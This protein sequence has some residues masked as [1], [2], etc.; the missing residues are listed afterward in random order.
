MSNKHGDIFG[1]GLYST[2]VLY[3]T[4]RE[5]QTWLATKD[6]QGQNSGS[7]RNEGRAPRDGTAA[8]T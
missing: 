3:R 2:V 5:V 8:M 7:V 4:V 1:H 6:S